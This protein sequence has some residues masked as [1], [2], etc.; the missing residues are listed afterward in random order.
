M[1]R[2]I[3]GICVTLIAFLTVSPAWAQRNAP[4]GGSDAGRGVDTGASSAASAPTY[5]ST[6]STSSYSGVYTGNVGF[7]GSSAGGLGNRPYY[8]STPKPTPPPISGSSFYNNSDYNYWQNYYNYLYSMYRFYPTYF[9]RFTKNYE[10][11]L[12]PAMLKIALREPLIMTS[13]MLRA[14]DDLET[15]L[16]DARAGKA[17]DRDAII[18]KS[19]EIRDY[20]KSVRQNQTISVIDIASKKTVDTGKADDALDPETI[21]KLREMA[22]DLNRQLTDLYSLA[23]SSTV[24]ADSFK[25]PS[26]ESQTKAI[27][28]ICRDIE[29]ASKRL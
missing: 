5:S 6:S 25:A 21:A 13:E 8:S 19:Q 11:K 4:A 12:T 24:S 1:R 10:P 22:L 17:V 7:A 29:H 26:F 18:S 20:A 28:K 15:M 2:L 27:E 16:A 3:L 23:S 14:I 9:S